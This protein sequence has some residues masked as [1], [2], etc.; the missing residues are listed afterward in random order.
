MKTS[1]EKLLSN[2]LQK[3]KKAKPH[4]K[5]STKLAEG[6]PSTKIIELPKKET[7]TS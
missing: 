2:A 1:H 7:L 3:V 4:L 6:R 5:V